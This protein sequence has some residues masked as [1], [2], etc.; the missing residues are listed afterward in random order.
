MRGRLEHRQEASRGGGR[1]GV[2]GEGGWPVCG[3]WACR[4]AGQLM[5]AAWVGARGPACTAQA[6][7][8]PF[9]P[10]WRMSLAQAAPPGC[11]ACCKAS[12]GISAPTA[13]VA[14]LGLVTVAPR[15]PTHMHTCLPDTHSSHSYRRHPSDE[16]KHDHSLV[17]T[18][19]Y[20]SPELLSSHKYGFETDVW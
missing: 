20:M 10:T 6:G 2:C 11:S 18:P 3:Q 8:C 1:V 19:H 17:G 9:L 12:A 4:A 5:A 14:S 13:C 15:T 7:C 16:D